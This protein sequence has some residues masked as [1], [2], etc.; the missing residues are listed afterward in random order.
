MAFVFKSEKDPQPSMRE[1]VPGPG[2]YSVPTSNKLELGYA[3]FLSTTQKFS[4]KKKTNITP[5]PGSYDTRSTF[6]AS[7]F[8]KV[9]FA[10]LNQPGETI[11]NANLSTT[12]KSRV[13]RFS[14]IDKQNVPGPGAYNQGGFGNKRSSRSQPATSHMSAAVEMIIEQNRKG[15]PSIPSHQ[16]SFGYS[17]LDS[18]VN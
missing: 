16:Y 14:H 10:T 6:E 12:F 18:I 3:P 15:I 13:P 9:C 1:T 7:K 2:R 17:E 4:D 11:L 5:G 8:Q